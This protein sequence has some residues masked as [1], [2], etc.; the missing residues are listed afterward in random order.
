MKA[1]WHRLRRGPICLAVLA[2]LAAGAQ[3][4]LAPSAEAAA[5]PQQVQV[6]GERVRGAAGK[7]TLEHAD[8]AHVPGSGGDPMRAVQSLPGVAH[9]DDGS[10]DPAVRGA[11]PS[12]N[13]YYVDFL[14]VGY[15][16][17]V[18]GFASVF[19]ADLIR[20]FDLASAAW[21]P[22]YGD[23][24]GAVFDVSLRSPRADRV[25]GKLDFSLL[26]ASV[27][28]EG[29]LSDKLAFF[30]SGRRSWFDLVAKTAETDE[31]GVSFTVPVYSDAQ[32]R[33][34]W[35]LNNQHSLRLDFSTAH[36]R[37]GIDLSHAS[38][39]AQRDPVLAG[40]SAQRQSYRTLA[41]TWDAS[42]ARSLGNTLA[43]GQISHDESFSLGSAGRYDLHAT[44]TY[45]REQLQ[46]QVSPAHRVLLGASI[47]SRLIEL[48][49]DFKDPRCTEFDPNCDLSSAARVLSLQHTRQ[50]LAD[51]YLSNRWRF[52][53]RW[54]ATGGLRVGRDDHAKQNFAEPRVG[55]EWAWSGDTL[56]SVALGRH[57]QPPPPEQA[58]QDVGNPGLRHLRSNHA[59][60]GVAQQLGQGWS[61]R[62]EAY[63]K[64]FDGYAVS[65]PQLRYRNGASGTAQG[66]ELLVK[67]DT[68][69][70]WSG[71]FS[72]SVSR[73]RRQHDGTGEEFPFEFDQPVIASLVGQYRLS[74]RWRFGA[75]WSYHTGA[76]YTPVVGTGTHPD[77]RVRPLYGA[78]NSKRVPDYH[79]L[80]L[81]VDWKRSETFTAYAE[82]INAYGRKNVSGYSYAADYQQRETLYQLPTL[83]SFGVQYGF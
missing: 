52:A 38:K 19:N 35:T 37:I 48:D 11:R 26:G 82:L 1:S 33:L 14:P 10:A 49:L 50:N 54:T 24:V 20:H 43:L 75:K 71:F 60:L 12:D 6:Q 62:V 53:P 61:W 51:L 74:D 79:R 65:D 59:V 55:L 2:T 58:L 28:V 72:L 63:A 32:G 15:L 76:P 36:D 83:I 57:N 27:L 18:G 25:G 81:R 16:F 77:G 40:H 64:T 39:A 7:S 17:H 5:P 73:A 4:Q 69:A 21:S 41:A 80:D 42:L 34:L 45:L 13:A 31:E 3:A 8:L 68:S 67:K 56:L 29:P 47:N 30:L 46:W 44:T 22:E 78:I 66:I 9:V 70:R 23:V